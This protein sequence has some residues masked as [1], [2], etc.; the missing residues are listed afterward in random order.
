[1]MHGDGMI[2]ES[3]GGTSS[4]VRAKIECDQ[5]VGE[6]KRDI[7]ELDFLGWSGNRFELYIEKSE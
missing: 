2:Y 7:D 6:C 4:D 3:S 5:I 1:R